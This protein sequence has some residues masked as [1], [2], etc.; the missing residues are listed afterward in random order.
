[1]SGIGPTVSGM[2]FTEKYLRSVGPVKVAG[3]EVKRYHVAA[4]GTEIDDGIQRAAYGLLPK[5][6]PPPDGEAPPASFVVLHRGSGPA[7]YLCAYSWVWGNVIEA[8][9]AAAGVPFLGCEDEDPENFRPLDRRW[10]GCVWELAPFEHERSAWVRHV[11][12]PA[13]PDL[14][15][16]L[17]DVAPDGMTGGPA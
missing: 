7:A 13:E 1:M 16:Y 10:I 2:A 4:I 15:G 8:R 14:D 5:L 12:T 17:A 6:L 11:L 3:R 9:T